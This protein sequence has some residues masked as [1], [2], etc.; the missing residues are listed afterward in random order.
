VH[1]SRLT[2]SQIPEN[3]RER[4]AGKDMFRWLERYSDFIYFLLRFVAGFLFACHGAQKLFG[5]LGGTR[6]HAVRPIVAGCIE[7]VA[8]PLI[9]AGLLTSLAAFVASG[10]MAFAYFLSHAP[11]DFWPIKNKGELAATLC[12]LFLYIAARGAGVI[13]I[14]HLIRRRRRTGS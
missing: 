1:P 13:S 12:F 3:S 9:A 7:L 5:V 6:A 14:D 10:E 11:R 4:L 2:S 8:G